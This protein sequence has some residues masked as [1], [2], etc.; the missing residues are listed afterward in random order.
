MEEN[1]KTRS[2]LKHAPMRNPGESIDAE[3]GSVLLNQ[4]VPSFFFAAA[5]VILAGFS[6]YQLVVEPSVV[7]SALMTAVALA[8]VGYAAYQ[9]FSV[10]KRVRN[11]QQGRDGEKT[12]AQ[13]LEFERNPDWLLLNDIPCDGFNID[14]L[15]LTTQGIFVIETKTYSKPKQGRPVISFDGDTILR[16]GRAITSDPIAQAKANRN[17]VR[18]FLERETGKVYPVKAAVA[19]VG[20]F[21]EGQPRSDVWVL[22]EQGVPKFIRNEQTR[23]PLEDVYLAKA[24]LQDFVERKALA[25]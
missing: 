4:A 14:H 11:L 22:N 2:P 24:R 8:S 23:I 19:F 9:L 20:W 18:D 6:W 10:R 12:V 1:H 3:I 5:M 21:I 15:L 7:F 13:Y 16:C 25:K 17:W